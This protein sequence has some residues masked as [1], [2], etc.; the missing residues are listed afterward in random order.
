[1][2]WTVQPR[3]RQGALDVLTGLISCTGFKGKP[4]T[5]STQF[6]R[7]TLTELGKQS[8][9]TINKKAQKLCL[10]SEKN[11]RLFLSA[12]NDFFMNKEL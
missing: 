6:L 9:L 5:Q 11:A 4:V 12:H 2:D 8:L 7:S 1:M 3:V 10:M